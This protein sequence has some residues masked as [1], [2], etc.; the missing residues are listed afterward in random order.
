MLFVQDESK[1]HGLEIMATNLII[2]QRRSGTFSTVTVLLKN[3]S[4]AVVRLRG[5]NYT[6]TTYVPVGDW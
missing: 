5:N 4:A 3:I 6:N 2:N 1:N